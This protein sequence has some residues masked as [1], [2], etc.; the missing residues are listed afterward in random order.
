ME[1]DSYYKNSER[2]IVG[3]SFAPRYALKANSAVSSKH[4]EIPCW[5][6]LQSLSRATP[7][8][9]RQLSVRFSF[10]LS[11]VKA[12]IDISLN[13]EPSNISK[14]PDQ[15]HF[16]K[17]DVETPQQQKHMGHML[18]CTLPIFLFIYSHYSSFLSQSNNI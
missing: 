11:V 18:Q 4:G 1:R 7:A 2:F 5:P 8:V 16:I 14:L 15:T 3:F 12:L 6:T 9:F 17:K 10:G 13:T